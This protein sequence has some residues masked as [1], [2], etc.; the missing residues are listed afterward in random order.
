MIVASM[1]HVGR[2]IAR[3]GDECEMGDEGGCPNVPAFWLTAPASYTVPL[4]MCAQHAADEARYF[5][6][7]VPA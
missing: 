7:E 5:G 6:T 2:A 3:P 1:R 4:L